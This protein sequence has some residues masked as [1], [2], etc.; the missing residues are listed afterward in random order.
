MSFSRS[1]RTVAIDSRERGEAGV[2]NV[3]AAPGLLVA[4]LCDVAIEQDVAAR[5]A[6]HSVAHNHEAAGA[7]SAGFDVILPLVFA[8]SVFVPVSRCRIGFRPLP[9]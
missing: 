5:W 3:I 8:G 4:R 1:R 7:Q 2:R 6:Q 9:R